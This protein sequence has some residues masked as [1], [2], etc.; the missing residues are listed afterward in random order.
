MATQYDREMQYIDEHNRQCDVYSLNQ[1]RQ[2]NYVLFKA[3]YRHLK[4]RKDSF[5]L[6]SKGECLQELQAL[7]LK[8]QHDFCSYINKR[9]PQFDDL[10]ST[11]VNTVRL[12]FVG[13]KAFDMRI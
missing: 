6:P 4:D 12:V 11:D 13:I 3:Y 10:S 5:K 7:S 2:N 8:T 1:L 9:L